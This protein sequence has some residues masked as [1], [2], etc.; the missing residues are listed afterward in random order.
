[1]N[2]LGYC[3]GCRHA[4]EQGQ[5]VN[6]FVPAAFLLMGTGFCWTCASSILSTLLT[7]TQLTNIVNAQGRGSAPSAPY[8]GG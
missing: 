1:M 2:H 4:A 8:K 7:Q 5:P 6:P 3:V